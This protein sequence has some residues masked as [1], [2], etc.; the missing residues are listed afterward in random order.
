MDDG[1]TMRPL[2]PPALDS[3][4][5][6]RLADEAA[7]GLARRMPEL[8]AHVVIT[9][10]Q[11]A[12][13]TTAVIAPLGCAVL[14]P[15]AMWQM[16]IWLTSLA[17]LIGIVFRAAISGIGMR[18]APQADAAALDDL[19]VYTIL[20]PLYRE[21]NVLAKLAEALAQLDYP[22]ALLDIKIIVE[23]DDDETRAA[24]SALAP[25]FEI[26]CVPRGE[27]RTKPRACNYALNFARGAF[28]VIY[29]AED[30]PEPTQ[31]KKA[32]A[33]FR[34]RPADVACLQARLNFFNASENWLTKVFAI[35]YALW[36]DIMLP[37]LQRLGVPMPLGGTSN[38]FRTET[39]RRLGGWDAFNVT[40]DADLGIRI[41]QLGGRVEMLDSITLEEAPRHWRVWKTQRARW[42]KGYMQTWL[43]HTRRPFALIGRAGLG[44]FLAFHLFIGGAVAAALATPLLWALFAA[45]MLLA[46]D[47]AAAISLSS[48]ITGNVLL[49]ALAM[50]APVRR[51]W[52]DLSPYGIGMALYWTLIA[53]AAWRGLKE[54]VLRPSHWDKTEHG[55]SRWA[56]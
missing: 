17:F 15:E 8:S 50:A 25:P 6:K 29:D 51:G 54:L 7:N 38:H 18:T 10:A 44:G 19:P 4:L 30:E 3:A 39:L 14:W 35:D 43:V 20:V 31:L 55:L 26:V 2:A 28:A 52:P 53:V 9:K 13:L 27:P 56:R 16:A 37:G 21:A 45:S 12:V 23:E 40:E 46:R 41:A 42:M 11:S 33:A 1:E 49:T 5:A 48:L 24:A 32:V 34:A 47:Q 36:F 22:P